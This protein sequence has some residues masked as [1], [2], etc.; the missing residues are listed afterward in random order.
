[1]RTKPS[2]E[3]RRLQSATAGRNVRKTLTRTRQVGGFRHHELRLTDRRCGAL[4]VRWTL[5]AAAHQAPRSH[6][7]EP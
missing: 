4:H 1:M 3:A 2:N 7:G 5:I 6:Q